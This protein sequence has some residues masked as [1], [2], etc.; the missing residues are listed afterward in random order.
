VMVLPCLP[1]PAYV[2]SFRCDDGGSAAPPEQL[3]YPPRCSPR[4]GVLRE[5]D[6]CQAVARRKKRAPFVIATRITD[7]DLIKRQDLGAGLQAKSVVLSVG[8]DCDQFLPA[9]N[10]QLDFHH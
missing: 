6:A 1:R 10:F 3:Q 7:D 5:R 4:R 8:D 9:G 2:N